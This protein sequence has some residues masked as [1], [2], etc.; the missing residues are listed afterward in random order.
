MNKIIMMRVLASSLR[1]PREPT[2]GSNLL[3]TLHITAISLWVFA[4][5]V[6]PLAVAFPPLALV[7]P[8][9]VAAVVRRERAVKRE[10]A[11][12]DRAS[13]DQAWLESLR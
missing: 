3:R 4:I 1:G 13:A 6:L 12:Y 8:F 10:R 5:F 7:V 2:R 9:L 11:E